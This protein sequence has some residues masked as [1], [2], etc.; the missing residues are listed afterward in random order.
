MEDI[1]KRLGEALGVDDV[2][3]TCSAM[4]LGTTMRFVKTEREG[5]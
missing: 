5:F 3:L 4:S 2:G 1:A